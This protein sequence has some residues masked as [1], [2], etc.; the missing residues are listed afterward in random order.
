M[1][2]PVRYPSGINNARLFSSTSI[3]A[4]RQNHPLYNLPVPDR[5]R[6]FQDFDD[7]KRYAAADWTVTAVGAST[8]ALLA[9]NGGFL[10]LLTGAINGNSENIQ[11][12]IASS[13]FVSGNQFWFSARITP[14]LA[15]APE[16]YFGLM[17]GGA[18]A[19]SAATDGVYFHSSAASANV[20]LVLA[21]ASVVTTIAA[22]ATLVDATASIWS[23][24]HDGAST[25]YYYKDNILLGSTTALTNL[26]VVSLAQQ[27]YTANGAAATNTLD[28][29][30]YLLAAE[31][32]R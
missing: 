20:D 15:V 9:G 21:K 16:Y 8:A 19:P 22:I 1:L 29:D 31:I 23:F 5:A 27:F 11:D 26:P 30:Y 7:F 28:I 32:A 12:A 10:R 18:T 6:L 24:Y 2:K 4:A 14:Q 3:G 13:A 25:L 17:N